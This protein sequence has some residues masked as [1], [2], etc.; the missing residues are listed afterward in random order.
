MS[1]AAG[2]ASSLYYKTFLELSAGALHLGNDD[3]GSRWLPHLQDASKSLNSLP[4]VLFYE[5]KDKTAKKYKVTK[6][7]QEFPLRGRR[8]E[9]GSRRRDRARTDAPDR[10]SRAE[11]AHRRL[12]LNRYR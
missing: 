3:L 7:N 5:Q 11:S 6:S 12:L 8:G 4:Q 2:A 1:I 9:P 10:R